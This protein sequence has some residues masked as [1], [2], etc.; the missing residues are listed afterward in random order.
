MKYV[1]IGGDAAGMSA[2]M[3][4]IRHEKS[5][6]VTT[7]ELGHIYSYG[8]CGL[9]Y[10]IS[11][12]IAS[13]SSLI[14]RSVHTFRD[15]Y[16]IDARTGVEV[17]MVDTIE[18]TV[19]GADVNTGAM[20]ECQYDKLLIAT[21]ASPVMPDWE[22]RDLENIFTLKTIPDAEEIVNH[23]QKGTKR[24]VIIGGGYIGLETAEAFKKRDVDVTIIDRGSRLAKVFDQDMAQHIHD[25]AASQDIRVILNEDVIGFKGTHAV[26]KVKTNHGQYSADIVI[27]ATGVKPNTDFLSD[28]IEKGANQAI[29]V[30]AYME[31][32]ISDV[33]A[34][35]DCALQYHR[36]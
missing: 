11:G 8:Q 19:H 32:S 3:Q 21:G 35:G 10:Y 30:N 2:A 18:K 26:E 22:G 31:T 17:K 9:P 29:K 23:I 5:A 27:V 4:I 24:A 28:D 14:A 15:Q 6:E 7:L 16:G 13:T 36:I 33:Y 1:I 12:D 34:A 20:I 25:E